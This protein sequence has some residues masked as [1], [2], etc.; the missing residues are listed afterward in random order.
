MATQIRRAETLL[1][2]SRPVDGRGNHCE[3]TAHTHIA[4]PACGDSRA[5]R[6]L[7]SAS[8]ATPSRN[9]RG[10]GR[11]LAATG[12]TR[13]QGLWPNDGRA[14]VSGSVLCE[15]MRPPLLTVT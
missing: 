7:R 9:L 8:H 1:Y 14:K 10:M 11:R 6:E 5:D 2:V 12:Q 13:G 4:R 15:T 3:A